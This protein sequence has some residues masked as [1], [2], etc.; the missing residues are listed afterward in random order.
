LVLDGEWQSLEEPVTQPTGGPNLM[1]N[2]FTEELSVFA[3]TD[4]LEE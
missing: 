3:G 2:T 4:P 1:V